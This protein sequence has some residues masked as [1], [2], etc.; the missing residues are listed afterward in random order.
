MIDHVSVQVG[1]YARSKD[2][3]VAA[4][5]PLGYELLRDFESRVGGFGRDG[6]PSFWIREGE[7]S[8]PIHIAFEAAK[9]RGGRGVLRS[10]PRGRRHRQWAARPPDDL[11]P[12]LLRRLRARSRRQQRRGGQPRRLTGAL[13]ARTSS[14]A[15]ARRSAPAGGSTASWAGARRTASAWARSP[16]GSRRATRT[17][18]TWAGS[19]SCSRPATATTKRARPGASCSTSTSAATRRS[20]RR[21]P[22]SSPA[23]RQGRRSSTSRGPGRRAR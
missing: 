15:T 18:S 1:D 12:G 3:Y 20:V 17:G 19:A 10:G 9:P 6:K 13:P 4:L 8:G 7:P 11:P 21:S 22:R 14:R 16:G 5:E 23:P 2:F